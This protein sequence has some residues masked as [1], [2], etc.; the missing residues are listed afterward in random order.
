[1]TS[2][3]TTIAAIPW[4]HTLKPGVLSWT[5]QTEHFAARIWG[6][7]VEQA[8][9]PVVR[10]YAW[11]LGDLIRPQQDLPRILVEGMT[12]SFEESEA[13]I[14]EHVGKC[15]DPRLGYSA[16]TG[17]Y[18]TTFMIATGERIDV[19]PMIGTRCTVEV[20]GREIQRLTGDL[21]VHHY[22]WRLRTGDRVVEVPP[23]H[24]RRITNR[25]VAAELARELT[26]SDTFTG[27]GRIH[28]GEWIR[29]CTGTPGFD[30]GTVD[31][32]GA[33]TCPVHEDRQTNRRAL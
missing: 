14:R 4:V 25:S 19:E 26:V 24:V 31:H 17:N 3:I 6:T 10:S 22:V 18:A 13:F 15:Y 1:M 12:A 21:T 8:P 27:F 28:R 30:L 33:Q 2:S 32:A 16:F 7:I 29:G 5:W 20:V 9:Q 11:E 23:E